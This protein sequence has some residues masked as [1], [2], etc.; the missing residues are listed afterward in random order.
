MKMAPDQILDAKEEDERGDKEVSTEEEDTD[1]EDQGLG[2]NAEMDESL[3]EAVRKPKKVQQKEAEEEEEGPKRRRLVV[4]R[5]DLLK[6]HSEVG[7]SDLSA[8]DLF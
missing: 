1:Q 3:E 2:G 7:Q 8:S 4:L 6:G 5:L